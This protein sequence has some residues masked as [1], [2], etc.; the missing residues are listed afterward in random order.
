MP[1]IDPSTKTAL[2]KQREKDL[3]EGTGAFGPKREIFHVF[4]ED[5][6]SPP[7]IITL[8]FLASVVVAYLG[9]FGA[10]S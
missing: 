7:K 4:R 2:E 6:K 1:T 9:L 3:G 5:A 8:A 10:V